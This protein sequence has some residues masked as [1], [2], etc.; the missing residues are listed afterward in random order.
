MGLPSKELSSSLCLEARAIAAAPGHRQVPGLPQLLLRA[1]ASSWHFK[2]FGL[3]KPM[4]RSP[5]GW[6]HQICEGGPLFAGPSWVQSLVADN[7]QRVSREAFVVKWNCP[8][9]SNKIYCTYNTFTSVSWYEIWFFV[10]QWGR[11]RTSNI[12]CR[13]F[14][15]QSA[16]LCF[17]GGFWSPQDK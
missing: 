2:D 14:S 6:C 12:I 7:H 5:V 16:C 15:S 3:R 9:T 8:H 4:G 1:P 17:L 11:P 10:Q 13:D